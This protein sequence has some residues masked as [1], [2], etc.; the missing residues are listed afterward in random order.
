MVK[1]YFIYV[2]CGSAAASSNLVRSRLLDILQEAKIDAS[3]EVARISELA[4][5]TTCRK[6][7]LIIITAGAVT[8]KG[9]P[10]GIPVLSGLPLM[11]MVGVK[12]FSIKIKEAL[13]IGGS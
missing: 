2:A 5:L 8:N 7:D 13:N 11:T 10:I 4:N 3:V 6:P 12:E 9:I 1:K